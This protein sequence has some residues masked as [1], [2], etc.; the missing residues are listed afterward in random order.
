MKITITG[1]T[2]EGKS[3]IALL[4]THSLAKAG[5]TNCQCLDE[6]ILSGACVQSGVSQR[7]RVKALVA[8]GLEINIE[9]VQEKKVAVVHGAGCCKDCG[10][11]EG[12]TLAPE[13]FEEDLRGDETPVW[14]CEP[15]RERSAREL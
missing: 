9:T 13:P 5:F 1:V 12:V 15:C 8:K 14:M 6:D 11:I 7:R 10:A 3:T 2:A 4:I